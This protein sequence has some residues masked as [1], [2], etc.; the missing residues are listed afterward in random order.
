MG[1]ILKKAWVL[2]M[3]LSWVIALMGTAAE[4]APAKKVDYPK[5]RIELVVPYPP[6]GITDLTARS[7]ASVLPEY[8]GQPVVVVNKAGGARLEGGEY[9]ASRKPDG[10]TLLLAPP[11]VG[12][13]EIHF[14]D[15]PYKSSDLVPVCQ[16][17]GIR[18]TLTVAA[19]SKYKSL[20]EIEK[21]LEANPD[22]KIQ[23]GNTG[24]GAMPHMVAVGF[25]AYIKQKDRMI[26]IP[27]QGDAGVITALLGKHIPL[28][29]ITGTGVVAQ[30]QAGTVRV[31]GITGEKRWNK[32]PDVPT[33]DELGY[34]LGFGIGDNSLYAPKKTPKEVIRVLNEAIAKA[35]QHKAFIALADKA[36]IPVEYE[37]HDQFMKTFE[38]RKAIM[39][40]LIKELGM[41]K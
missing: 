24:A 14:K 31:L 40:Q 33:L 11:S 12:W 30:A 1:I 2:L 32:L 20:K 6:G 7:L 39:G 22:L 28:G 19:D 25:A 23:V 4:C 35:I 37:P 8:L 29:S 41:L 38:A 10:Y 13:P 16:V 27:F 5:K 26:Q 36:G 18:Q 15:P 34:K 17:I 9:V 21:D 3:A